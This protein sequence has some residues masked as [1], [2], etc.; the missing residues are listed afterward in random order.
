MRKE[1]KIVAAL[2]F[3]LSAMLFGSCADGYEPGSFSSDVRNAQLVSPEITKACFSTVNSSSGEK[4][5]LTWPLVKGA[6]GYL[7]NVG[8]VS[9]EEIRPIVNDSIVDGVTVLFDKLE[10]TKYQIS[11]KALGNKE[12]GNKD[13][14]D[15][16]MFVYSTMIDGVVVPAGNDIATFVNKYIADHA[17]EMDAA[18][19]ESPAGYEIAFE[20]EHGQTYNLNDSVD[21]RLYPVT[22]RS[23]DK[24]DRAIVVVGKNGY[25][26]TSGGLKVK[27]IN[28]DCTNLNKKMGLLSFSDHPD[29]SI[30]TESLGYK[31]LGAN[32]DA[33][34]I[35]RPVSFQ[36]CWIKNLPATLV[37]GNNKSWAIRDFSIKDCI[38]QAANASYTTPWINFVG[39][40]A[41]GFK[42]LT[43]ENSTF[44]NTE[45][46]ESEQYFMRYN[47]ASNAQPRKL[48]GDA[49]NSLNYVIK[50]NNFIRTNPKKDFAN[51]MPNTANGSGV[52]NQ[53]RLSMT[54]N[55]FFDTY[56]IYQLV[57]TQWYKI[58]TGNFVSYSG[59]CAPTETDYAPSG[60]TDSAGNFYTT[61]DESPAYS[62]AQLQ[63]IDFTKPNGGLNLAPAGIAGA[64]QSGDPRW[65]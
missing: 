45:K 29:A 30:S 37:F 42:N 35:N 54:D 13:A 24:N 41:G 59:L 36:G 51:N 3:C 1:V 58:T 32:Q 23:S 50:N 26:T 63:P 28:F 56:R 31:A 21:F 11:V 33:F 44:Y 53:I 64:A 5:Q 43:I 46:N 48:Y 9:G 34:V 10:D 61:L 6:S 16:T 8:I 19:A 7:V 49:D 14:T 38:V 25:I 18:F 39:S 12:L 52:D 20:L 60:R 4:V 17:A 27:F 40:S 57:Q 65:Y 2:G 47:N 15:A 22:F 55:V 62:D